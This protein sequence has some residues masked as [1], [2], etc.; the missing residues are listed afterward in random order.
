ML[1]VPRPQKAFEQIKPENR[2]H[3]RVEQRHHF[4]RRRS[5]A[6]PPRMKWREIHRVKPLERLPCFP[7]FALAPRD[8][9]ANLLD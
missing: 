4:I 2:R 5:L 7:H 3:R 1:A 9:R 6:V 8:V